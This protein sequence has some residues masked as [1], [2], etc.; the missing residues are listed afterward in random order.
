[1][2]DMVVLKHLQKKKNILYF[3][4]YSSGLEL[5]PVLN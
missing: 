4:E 1:M 3:L 5:N 2:A